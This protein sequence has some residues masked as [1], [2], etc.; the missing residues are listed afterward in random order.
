MFN[1][2]V[3]SKIKLNK[4]TLII[5]ICVL[6]LQACSKDSQTIA[7]SRFLDYQTKTNLIFPLRGES[8]IAWGGRTV[9]QNAHATFKDQRFALD[10]LALKA[11][12]QPPSK[13][14]V[15]NVKSY[16][17][18]AKL[19]ESYYI[20][21]R[22]IL[23]PANGTVVATLN[24]VEDN[25]P[26]KFNTVQ[27]AGNYVV[28]DHGNR[29][30]SMIG[31]LKIDSV[32]VKKGDIVRSGEVIGLVGNSGNSSEPHLHYHLQN[33]PHWQNGEGLPAQF[34]RY[35]ANGVFIEKGEPIQGQIIIRH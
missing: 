14:D 23:A 7:S 3:T 2:N 32:M 15:L 28:I 4:N 9:K 22:D 5:F 31:H 10:I 16:Q 20:F 30:Y 25:I 33:T 8:Y 34:N 12:S 27:P 29:E 18:D 17:G 1:N 13:E 11:G 24:G 26:G 21:G 35:T 19:N 6:L